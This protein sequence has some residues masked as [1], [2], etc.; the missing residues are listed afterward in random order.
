MTLTFDQRPSD[1]PYIDR[2]WHSHSERPGVFSSIAALHWEMVVSKFEGQITMTIRGPE[3]CATRFSYPAGAEWL[4][5]D[6]KLGTFLRHLPPS[7]VKNLQ[8]VTLPAT[9]FQSFWLYGSTWR[10]PDFENAETFVTR[11]V[12]AELLAQ[13]AVVEAMLQGRPHDLSPRAGQYR[14]VHA[15]GISHRLHQ[16]IA[17]ARRAAAC[18]KQGESIL[19]TVYDAGYSDQP[20][21]TRALKHFIGCTPA[22]INATPIVSLHKSE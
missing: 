16:Q 6:F 8:D 7:R 11:L 4:G 21:L 20:H 5:I 18:L 17:R 1:S 13:D 9:A 14:F 22:E 19:D 2:V 3:T 12:R 15:T 10:L